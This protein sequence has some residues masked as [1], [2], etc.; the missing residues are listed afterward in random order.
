MQF[1]V[2]LRLADGALTFPEAAAPPATL[3]AL[4]GA[5][6]VGS[7]LIF[8]ALGYLLAVFKRETFG[9]G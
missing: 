7:V 2:A 5:L 3:Q 6:V 9:E 4:L 8:P 1:P